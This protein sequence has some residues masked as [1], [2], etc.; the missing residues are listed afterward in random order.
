M[1]D[2]QACPNCRSSRIAVA[3][4]GSLACADCCTPALGRNLSFDLEGRGAGSSDQRRGD[5]DA[6]MGA[7]LH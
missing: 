3:A 1:S 6:E 7:R 5:C 2:A 4:D